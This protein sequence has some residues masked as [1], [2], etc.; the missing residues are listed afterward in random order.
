M[1]KMTSERA[2]PRLG[3]GFAIIWGAFVA[4]PWSSVFQRSPAIYRPMLAVV[5][6]E[7]F[8]GLLIL[9]FGLLAMYLQRQGKIAAA[10]LTVAIPFY[11]FAPLYL[12]ADYGS[13]AGPIWGWIATYN[14]LV[15]WE[16][17][18]ELWTS[19]RSLTA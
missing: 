9:A 5:P 19:K 1:V 8:W 7:M 17:R 13:P 16:R 15:F 3:A 6:S 10:C 18:G 11:S 14:F 2:A 4:W 12:M